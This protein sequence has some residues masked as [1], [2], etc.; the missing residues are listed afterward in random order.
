MFRKLLIGTIIVAILIGGIVWIRAGRNTPEAAAKNF[1]N[2]LANGK[3]DA[4]Y[5]T[6]TPQLTKGREAYWHDYLKQFSDQKTAPTFGKEDQVVDTFN[7]YTDAQDPHR[8]RYTFH[9]K[10][11]DYQMVILLVKE[12]S[13]WKVDELNGS[14]VTR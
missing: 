14:S 10:D 6:L 8:F 9:L 3:T 11:K 7:T 5:A 12:G 4:A 1:T 13:A 2:N